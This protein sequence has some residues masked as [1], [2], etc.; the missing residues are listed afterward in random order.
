M[1]RALPAGSGEVG[2]V[3][4]PDA[5]V[6]RYGAG[7]RAF[8]PGLGE[9]AR[10][11]ND[12]VIAAEVE[13]LDVAAAAVDDVQQAL[14]VA[15]ERHRRAELRR[16]AALA[17]DSGHLPAAAAGVVEG[18]LAHFVAVLVID[19]G[20]GAVGRQRQQHRI[21]QLAWIRPA[22][23]AGG[24]QLAIAV[25]YRDPAQSRIDD[26]DPALIVGGDVTAVLEL[27]F[28]RPLLADDER[29][30]EF[31]REAQQGLLPAIEGPGGGAI[32]G[33]G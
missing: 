7:A 33:D 26:G 15:A 4:Q 14:A 31:G 30:A 25:E 16:T 28:V 20:R 32:A 19:V 29:L 21:L 18:E 27:A 17:A 12:G 5:A 8:Q 6:G 10:V 9:R 13:H 22:F 24:D 3:A 23:A 2:A 1:T 11:Q